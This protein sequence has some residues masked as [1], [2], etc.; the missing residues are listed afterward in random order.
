MTHALY[1][2]NNVFDLSSFWEISVQYMSSAVFLKVVYTDFTHKKK[3]RKIWC[4][5]ICYVT[6]TVE[7]I[8]SSSM[9]PL[10]PSFVSNT[11]LP[12]VIELAKN[13]WKEN[14]EERPTFPMIRRDVY[15]IR[16]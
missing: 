5:S 2:I 15:S 9:Y 8:K 6:D 10:R 7:Q 16:R 1:I 3:M 4:L 12:E 14:P 11:S 13:C